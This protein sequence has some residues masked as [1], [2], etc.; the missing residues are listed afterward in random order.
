LAS[1]CRADIVEKLITLRESLERT[2]WELVNRRKA[3]ITFSDDPLSRLEIAGVLTSL[4]RN[5]EAK[6][7]LQHA[8][9]ESDKLFADIPWDCTN[10]VGRCYFC[11]GEYAEALSWFNRALSAADANKPI[12]GGVEKE[13]IESKIHALVALS[14]TIDA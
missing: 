7:E 8:L 4:G 9:G 5:E 1:S 12:A 6:V 14:R 3:L 10:R 13:V 11:Y 2:E